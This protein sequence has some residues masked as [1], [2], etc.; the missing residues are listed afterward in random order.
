MASRLTVDA[1]GSAEPEGVDLPRLFKDAEQCVRADHCVV[2]QITQNPQGDSELE[3]HHIA[4]KTRGEPNFPDT[5]TVCNRCHRY[6]SDHQRAWS[7]CSKNDAARL[8]SYFFG[9]AD[10]FDLLYKLSGTSGFEKL[11]EKF[12]SQGYY[13]R[14]ALRERR[15]VP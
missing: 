4:G 5:I 2:C 11:A 1:S 6:L 8:S 3:E 13:I 7:S 15:H 12:R 10:I 9:W 14:N